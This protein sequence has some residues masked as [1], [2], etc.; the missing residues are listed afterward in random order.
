MAKRKRVKR[1]LGVK[2]P[3]PL[4]RFLA[5]PGGQIA[6]A[7]AV[8]AAGVGAARSTRVREAFGVAGHELRRA[9]AAAAYAAGSATKSVLTPVIGAME[10]ASGGDDKSAKKKARKGTSRLDQDD[11]ETAS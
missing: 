7:G 1:V 5:T 8:L 6:I 2:V 9:G 4:G 11:R 10:Q 3:K